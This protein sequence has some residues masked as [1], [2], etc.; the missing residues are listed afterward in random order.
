M[1]EDAFRV[2]FGVLWLAFFGVRV[3]FGRRIPPGL[4]YTRILEGR[5]RWLFRAFALGYLA[6]IAYALTPWLD[7]G[8]IALA[9]WMRWLGAVA[10]AA[11]IVLFAWAHS[12][13]GRNWTAVLA[14]A[15]DH[16]MV[17]RGPYRS[18][19]HPMYSAFFIIGL[20]FSLL[21]AN[22]L[23]ALLY[24]GTLLPMYL[25]RVSAEEQMMIG[26]FGGAYRQYMAVTGRLIPR[27]ARR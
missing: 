26:R 27:L 16:E 2:A 25:L 15:E 23:V 4:S 9:S 14:L 7:V 12:A 11:G 21:S 8:R 5:E 18:V 3:H 20:G 10:L 19:R 22:W 13:L 1:G 24:L 6:I 17:T